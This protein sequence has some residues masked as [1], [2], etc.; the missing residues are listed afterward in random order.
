MF[1]IKFQLNIFIIRKGIIML[2]LGLGNYTERVIGG[3]VYKIDVDLYHK[4]DME[5]HRM[6]S[7]YVNNKAQFEAVVLISNAAEQE[8]IQRGFKELDKIEEEFYAAVRFQM[9]KMGLEKSKIN[10]MIEEY[11]Y[12]L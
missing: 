5:E 11:K 1:L 3:V 7:E 6:I 9:T 4:F 2:D 10:S 8:L 12:F